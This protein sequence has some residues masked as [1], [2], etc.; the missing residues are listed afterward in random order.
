MR[1]G[2]RQWIPIQSVPELSGGDFNDDVETS[3]TDS[4]WFMDQPESLPRPPPSVLGLGLAPP[5]PPLQSQT[6]VE[7]PPTRPAVPIPAPS[8][9]SL[10]RPSP[11]VYAGQRAYDEADDDAA[12]RVASPLGEGPPPT[13]FAVDDETMTRV[14]AK[15][16]AA[17]APRVAGVLPTLPMVAASER[18][19]RALPS[20]R[21]AAGAPPPASERRNE[22]MPP[23]QSY[24][25]DVEVHP[26][27]R[28]PAG[29]LPPVAPLQP[30][31]QSVTP[32]YSELP[33]QPY[34]PYD[35]RSLPPGY[36][37]P[38]APAGDQGLKALVALIVF[39]AVALAIVVILLIVRH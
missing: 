7:P 6:R 1:V 3:V 38:P 37:P 36:A 13:D 34:P 27:M 31:H 25:P 21:P 5:R 14:A 23:T 19:S 17:P 35:P 29:E 11:D 39:L 18:M 16:A 15:P 10:T 24:A 12:T 9:S 22:P 26:S 32:F 2:T 33:Q 4:P 8:P 28:I 30:P 20:P